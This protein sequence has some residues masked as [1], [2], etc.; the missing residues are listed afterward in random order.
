VLK[1]S[2]YISPKIYRKKENGT[3]TCDC[4]ISHD[5]QSIYDE[6]KQTDVQREAGRTH[7]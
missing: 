2:P 7:G 3:L 5:I 1:V 6:E 4:N